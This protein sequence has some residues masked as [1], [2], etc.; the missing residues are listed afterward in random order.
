[1]ENLWGNPRKIDQSSRFFHIYDN[2][3][4][5]PLVGGSFPCWLH[6]SKTLR[7]GIVGT[8]QGS[9]PKGA[10]RCHS[11]PDPNWDG[12]TGGNLPKE[13][14]N[15]VSSFVFDETWIYIY[16]YSIFCNTGKQFLHQ[17]L[18]FSC[19]LS[20]HP[21]QGSVMFQFC[22]WRCQP[23]TPFLDE[24]TERVAEK[25]IWWFPI[26]GGTPKWMVYS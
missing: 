20:L 13:S 8:H 6:D 9:K 10:A 12:R 5:V 4:R 7:T 26:N 25:V 22:D 23:S 15:Y 3:P 18:G 19:V 16:I 2:L 1:M 24:M 14:K 21:M 17:D 11:H